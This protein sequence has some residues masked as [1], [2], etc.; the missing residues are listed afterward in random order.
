[1]DN[2]HGVLEN[3]YDTTVLDM[4]ISSGLAEVTV[5]KPTLIVDSSHQLV[6]RA[7]IRGLTNL[8]QETAANLRE[9][10]GRF[11]LAVNRGAPKQVLAELEGAVDCVLE[12]STALQ[13]GRPFTQLTVKKMR[14]RKFD[15]RPVKTRIH[16]SKGIVFEVPKIHKGKQNSAN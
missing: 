16:P 7:S 10:K 5:G 11:F 6:E 13:S 1:M 15:N 4:A 14:G 12:L 8:I 2:S 9:E 3:F